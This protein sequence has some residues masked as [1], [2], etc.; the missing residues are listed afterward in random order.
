MTFRL[1]TLFL[2]AISVALISL[3]V[4]SHSQLRR[5]VA[6]IENSQWQLTENNRLQCQLEHP[7][8]NYGTAIFSSAASKLNNLAF[9][10]DL[11]RLPANYEM[12]QVESVPPSWRPGEGSSKVADLQWRKQFNGDLDEKSAWV[13]LTELEKGYIPTFY[14]ADWYNRTDRVA[15]GLAAVNFRPAYYEFLDCLD[16]LLPYSFKDISY[17]VLN[18]KNNSAEL[19]KASQK[20]LAQ[21][22][23][24]LKHDTEIEAIDVKAYSSS[25]G[26]RYTNLKVSEKRAKQVKDFFVKF[27]IDE[28]KIATEGFG[29]KRHIASN[30]T[31]LGR[32]ENRRVVIEMQKP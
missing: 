17:V 6:T 7:I 21:I 4:Q 15:V 5:Y 20:K 29:E 26:G 19:D 8:P 2:T 23:E 12:A 30:E 32:S 22:E 14:Y 25:W 28:S 18:F 3:E 11:K 9:E 16:T 13:M 27:G 1:F 24:Y 10:L 31:I